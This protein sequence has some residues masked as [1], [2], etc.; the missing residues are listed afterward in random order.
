MGFVPSAFFEDPLGQGYRLLSSMFVHG[1]LGHLLSN[2][3]FLW[4]FGPALESRLSSWRYFGLYILAGI[5]AAMTQAFFTSEP[6]VPMVGASGAIAGVTG[7]YLLLFA[8]AY[9]LTWLFPAFWVWL[10]ASLYLGYWAAIQIINALLGMPGVAWWAHLGGFAAGMLL[11]YWGKPR[12]NYKSAP[13]WESWY[14]FR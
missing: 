1:S 4:V 8:D 11:A 9:V 7:G 10:P 5:A 6:T 3:W 2:M 14:Y 12:R 13:V